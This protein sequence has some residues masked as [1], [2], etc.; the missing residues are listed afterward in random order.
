MLHERT[1]TEGQQMERMKAKAKKRAPEGGP[2]QSAPQEA[3][4]HS[5]ITQP[6]QRPQNGNRGLLRK[7]VYFDKDEWEAIEQRCLKSDCG[8]ADLVRQAIQQYLTSN[9]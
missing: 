2:I 9:P 1:V 6:P 7:T 5:S 3:P 8:Y 4:E